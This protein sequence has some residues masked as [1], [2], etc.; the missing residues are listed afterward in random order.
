MLDLTLSK[1]W[2]F[3]T[4]GVCAT[5]ELIGEEECGLIDWLIDISIYGSCCEAKSVKLSSID[6]HCVSQ[7]VKE[8]EIKMIEK[9]ILW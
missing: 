1:K 4:N 7:H 6:E 8:I 5:V 2:A 3:T 9:Y